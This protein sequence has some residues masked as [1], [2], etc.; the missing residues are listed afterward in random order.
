MRVLV[1]AAGFATRLYPLTRDRAKP[2]LDVAGRPVLSHLL[3]RVLALPGIREV[4]VVTNARFHRDFQEWAR[5]Y[6]AR[7]PLEVVADGA[8]CDDDKLGALR[9]LELAWRHGDARWP[10]EDVLVV[11]GD[12]LIGFDL[13]SYAARFAE[14]RRPMLMARRIEGTVPPKRHGEVTIDASGTVTRF[15]EKPADPESDLAA[16]CLYLFPAAIKARLDSYLA[17]PTNPDAPGHFMAWLAERERM[18]AFVLEGPYFDIGDRAS[19]DEARRRYRPPPASA[20][21]TKYHGR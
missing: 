14:L 9:D 16:I 21:G 2:L 8:T 12:N 5:A 4:T 6:D 1:L 20:G 10:D 18:A 13:A 19:L 7:V 3:D 11:A 17:E 15:R